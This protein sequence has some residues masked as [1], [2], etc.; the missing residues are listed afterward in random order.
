MTRPSTRA[1]I[2][3]WKCDRPAA[4]HGTAATES[5][6]SGPELEALVRGVVT[7][8]LGREPVSLRPG[9]GQ[10][11]HLTFVATDVGREYFVRIEDGPE[12]DDY[13]AVE[14]LVMQ[15]LAAVGVPTPQLFDA[16]VSRCE[17]PFAWQ[18]LAWVPQF[19]LNRHFKSGTLDAAAVAEQTGRLIAAWQDVVV[20]GFGPFDAGIAQTAGR[21][22]GLHGTYANYFHTRLDAHLEFLAVRG[23]LGLDEVRAIRQEIDAHRGLLEFGHGVLVHK[24]LAL[25]NL[26]GEPDRI[27]AVIDWDDCV[28]GD[29][30]D[31]LSLLACFHDGA[32]LARALT[33]Y[34][35]RR[36]LPTDHRRRFWLHLLRNL[37]FKSVIRV[38]AGYFERSANFFLIGAGGSGA[39]LKTFTLRRLA[40]ARAGLRAAADPASL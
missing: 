3:Y 23:F 37:L 11:N 18:I 14:S 31:D 40:V 6:R 27:T 30:L 29:P 36:A 22:A 20:E 34:R 35:S 1:G 28:G 24:D 7:R 15:R 26:L 32:F 5:R 12:R 19:D 38:G 25:W 16:D 2:Y 10:G 33:G 13:L 21:L 4:F 8:Y 39:D 9:P 17:V